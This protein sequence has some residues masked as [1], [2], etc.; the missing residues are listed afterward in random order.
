MLSTLECE[1]N[2]LLAA[3]QCQNDLSEVGDKKTRRIT[4]SIMVLFNILPLIPLSR[5]LSRCLLNYYTVLISSP[6]DS[7][8]P[9]F[10]I[11]YLLPQVPS[12]ICCHLQHIL[13]RFLFLFVATSLFCITRHDEA[14]IKVPEGKLSH[15]FHI[16]S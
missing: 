11:C 15:F 2:P 7:S 5:S 1:L 9:D 4:I 12:S 16:Y 8:S 3:Y 14:I 6:L 10:I 13:F